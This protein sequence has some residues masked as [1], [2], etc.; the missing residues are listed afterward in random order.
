MRD[1]RPLHGAARR[2]AGRQRHGGRDR[3]RRHHPHDGRARGE[4][5]LRAPRRTPRPARWRSQVEGL[6]RRGN[7]QR[8]ARDRARRRLARRCGAAR[9]S[10]SPAWSAPGA[11]RRRGRSSAPIRSIPA[12]ILV[13]GEPVDDP[14]AAG[15]HPPRHRPGAGGPQAAG[16]VPVARHPHEL[17]AWP[18]STASAAGASSSTS[19]PRRALVEEYRRALNIRMA[20]PEQLVGNLSGGNQQKVVLAR[21]L[22]LQ[23]KGADRRRADARHRRRRQGRGAQPPVRDGARPASPSS[24]SPRSCRK[25]WR[26]ATASSRCARGGSPARSGATTPTRRS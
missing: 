26:S 5:A 7:A 25:C 18:R 15:R 17:S 3:H 19:A 8:P 6:T 2:P 11:R 10:A 21:W 24:R 12:D 9:S 4:R 1:L 14:L 23:A 13:G 22:A 20:G 16:A